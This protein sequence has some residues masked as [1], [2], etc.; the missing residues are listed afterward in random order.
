VSDRP[1]P[2]EQLSPIERRI[3]KS[4][5]DE[6]AVGRP[7]SRRALRTSRSVE[8]YLKAGLIPRYMERLRDIES[9]T[10]DHKRRIAAS[11]R[12]LQ[13]ACGDDTELFARLWR[14]RA[15][16][17][18]FKRLN[19]LIREHNEWYPVEADLPIDLRTRDYVLIR[20]RSYRRMELGAAW[21]L[22]HFPASPRPA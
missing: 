21:I 22:E 17:W 6:Q 2:S 19:E 18:S 11:Y 14:A 1:P 10:Q 8:A 5:E 4:Y 3:A 16:S 13:D 7:L 15:E 9:Q 12:A 20:G